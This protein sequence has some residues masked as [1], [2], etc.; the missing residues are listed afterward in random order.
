MANSHTGSAH[1]SCD[2]VPNNVL[3]AVRPRDMD[4]YSY[5]HLVY[6]FA[7]ISRGDWKLTTT[8][9]DDDELIRELQSLKQKN[10]NLKTMWAV[11]GWAFNVSAR[12][13]IPVL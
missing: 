13:S 10:P 11:G 5:T 12:T 4:P 3:P 8:Q 7:S 1:R 9:D 2:G 6:S